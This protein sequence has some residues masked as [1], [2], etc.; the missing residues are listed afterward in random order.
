M[1]AAAETEAT[2]A[3][4]ESSEVEDCGGIVL[5]ENQVFDIPLV[6]E[7]ENGGV[8]TVLSS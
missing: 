3:A 7:I 1:N 5:D 8:A 4:S 6:L 2:I